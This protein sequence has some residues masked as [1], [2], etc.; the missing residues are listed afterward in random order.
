VH[1]L[2]ELRTG[3]HRSLTEPQLE[4]V[5][6]DLADK[7]FVVAF[8]SPLSGARWRITALGKSALAEEGLG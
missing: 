3:A 6:R 4:K 1:L 7:S 2:P 8:E 5:L